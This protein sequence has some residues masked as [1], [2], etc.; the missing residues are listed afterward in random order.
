[1]SLPKYLDLILF[2][3]ET[4]LLIRITFNQLV[5]GSKPINIMVGGY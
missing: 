4:R 3:Y 1:M 2:L 5:Q